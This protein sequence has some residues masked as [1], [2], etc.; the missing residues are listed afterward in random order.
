ME[1]S[2]QD[3]SEWVAFFVRMSDKSA[4]FNTDEFKAKSQA[5]W[6][7]FEYQASKDLKS[8]V[9]AGVRSKAK[10]LLDEGLADDIPGVMN[11]KQMNLDS[12]R[13]ADLIDAILL[14]LRSKAERE[15]NDLKSNWNEQ[16]CRFGRSLGGDVESHGESGKAAR[17]FLDAGGRER[18]DACDVLMR[19]VLMGPLAQSP[20]TSALL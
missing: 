13:K 19:S 15:E 12:V 9:I 14:V 3:E 5:E 11:L 2:L 17:S 16:L 4:S 7:V 6:S 20:N 10:S 1:S 8:M 18:G